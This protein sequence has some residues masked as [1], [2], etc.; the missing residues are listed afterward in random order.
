MSISSLV[1]LFV[2]GT[3][4]GT[5]GA[6]LGL[7]GG[8]FLVPFLVL[9]FDLPMH[10][11]IATSIIAVIATSSAGASI[12]IE[13]QTVN[14]RLGMVLEIAT[15]TGAILGGVTAN[16]LDGEILRKIFA[17][18][19][20]IVSIAMIWR[21]KM[22]NGDVILHTDGSLPGTFRDEASDQTVAYTVKRLPPV[23]LISLLAGNI[24]G[25]LGVGGGIFKVP[26]MTMIAGMPIK[27]AT[28]TSNFMIG[29]T[30]AASAFIYFS[31]GHVNPLIASPTIL[32][33]LGGSLLGV[34]ISQRIKGTALTWIFA[35][36]LLAISLQMYWR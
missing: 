36:L 8:V 12:N 13:R 16:L 4:T 9:A 1:L 31:H 33:V 10:Q 2:G 34:T 20:L 25:L 32:G 6:M 15:V 17:G 29:V 30:A 11:A 22:R 23:M 19:L 21:L 27:A 24:S 3:V 26:A 7:G 18:L 28:A 35:V 5:I 14:I